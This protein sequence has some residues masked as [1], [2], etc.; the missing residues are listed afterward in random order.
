MH[1]VRCDLCLMNTAHHG[2]TISLALDF[3]ANNELWK[4]SFLHSGTMKA[5]HPAA[6][7]TPLFMSHSFNLAWGFQPCLLFYTVRMPKHGN[8]Y[9]TA[10]CAFLVK[11]V[12]KKQHCHSGNTVTETVCCI[13]SSSNPPTQKLYRINKIQVFTPHYW[14]MPSCIFL[15]KNLPMQYFLTFHTV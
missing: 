4:H 5:L 11:Q 3:V 12:F 9:L 10:Y 13:V 14:T 6:S 1:C 7:W 15:N 2:F 8:L